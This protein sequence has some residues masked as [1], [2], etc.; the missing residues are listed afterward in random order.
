MC[1]SLGR[2]KMQTAYRVMSYRAQMLA[3][4]ANREKREEGEEAEDVQRN[5]VSM[6]TLE[7]FNIGGRRRQDEGLLL[8]GTVGLVRKRGTPVSS[9]FVSSIP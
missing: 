6:E 3:S 8:N 1:G 7:L 2:S 4:L 9:S 5:M